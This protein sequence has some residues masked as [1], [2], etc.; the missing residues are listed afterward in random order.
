VGGGHNGEFVTALARETGRRVD[1]TQATG[2]RNDLASETA[3]TT[4]D[5]TLMID[6]FRDVVQ[7]LPQQVPP[8]LP[9][10][11]Q[12]AFPYAPGQ[13]QSPQPTANPTYRQPGQGYG[14]GRQP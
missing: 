2:H 6:M 8:T 7:R 13:T 14:Q 12:A 9:P 5:L 10:G 4:G 1:W 3:R 11:V